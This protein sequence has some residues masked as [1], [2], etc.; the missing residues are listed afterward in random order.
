MDRAAFL[1]R[2]SQLSLS[3]R[4]AV[5]RS[6]RARSIEKALRDLVAAQLSDELGTP[7]PM[8]PRET[9]PEPPSSFLQRVGDV[10]P[11]SRQPSLYGDKVPYWIER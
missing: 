2:Q 7:P 6:P 5:P 8:I 4:K 10:T 3:L 9:P 11:E 1:D